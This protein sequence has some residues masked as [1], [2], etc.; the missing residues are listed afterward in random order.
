MV[1][2]SSHILHEI[3]ATVDRIIII[4]TGK[5]VADGSPDE[6][7]AGFKGKTL[8]TLEIK[9]AS[10]ENIENLSKSLAG[11]SLTKVDPQQGNQLAI[12]EYDKHADPR[13]AIFKHALENNW[14]LLEM[15]PKKTQLE[16][17]FRNLTV[18]GGTDA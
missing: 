4:H 7:M 16:D 11:V 17:I 6:L 15:S 2:I 3:E 13:E 10:P 5:L 14:I 9:N 18:N 12:M 1:I 8:L